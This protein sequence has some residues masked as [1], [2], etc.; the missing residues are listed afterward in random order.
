LAPKK[1]DDITFR[2]GVVTSYTNFGRVRGDH[3]FNLAEHRL[4]VAITMV[5]VPGKSDA[6]ALMRCD[7]G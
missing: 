6:V 5:G 3:D 4:F 1:D 7:C 2:N